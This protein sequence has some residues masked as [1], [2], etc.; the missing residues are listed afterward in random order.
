MLP[1]EKWHVCG[2]DFL[3]VAPLQNAERVDHAHLARHLCNRKTS[4]GADQLVMIGSTQ[5]DKLRIQIDIFNPDG[6]RSPFCGN[7]CIAAAAYASLQTDLTNATL[8]LWIG[9]DHYSLTRTGDDW[10]LELPQP[11]HWRSLAENTHEMPCQYYVLNGTH[12]RVVLC[13]E[14]PPR[15]L[16][17]EGVR[18]S[19]IPGMQEACNVMFVSQISRDNFFLTPWERGGTGASLA[20]GSGA[21]AA[22]WVLYRTGLIGPRVNAIC[23]GGIIH[24]NLEQEERMWVS[25]SPV[26]TCIGQV[27]WEVF[28]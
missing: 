13:E 17:L 21:S 9:N 15:D 18:L 3:F 11:E 28:A 1:F 16:S 19:W 12:H 5:S 10:R 26:R 7:A 6:S 24:M 2:N 20:C 25:A 27:F 23:P 22:A 8:D 14:H 4:I